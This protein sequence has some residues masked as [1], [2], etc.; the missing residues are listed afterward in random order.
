MTAVTP[1]RGPQAFLRRTRAAGGGGF[2]PSDIAGLALWLKADGTLWQDSGRT[3]PASSDAD[4]VGAW[5]DAS[6]ND[7]HY[8][9]ATAGSRPA[10]KTGIVNGLPVVR[11]DGASDYLAGPNHLSAL[12]A[13]TAFVVV[14]IDNDPPGA[15]DQSGLWDMDAASD[16]AH[17][18]FTDGNVYDGWGSTARKSTGNPTLS[19]SAAFRVYGVVSASGA[20]TS[21]VDGTQHYT[22]GTNTVGFGTAPEFGRSFNGAATYYYLDGDVAEVIV[23]DS[24]LG[25]TDRQSVEGYLATKYG[26]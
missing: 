6:G 12:T 11:F 15:A 21:Y 23:Y 10:F 17:Y 14:K 5:D 4:P 19:L 20:W 24:A 2:S 8:T 9:Q 7:D 22:T 18:P 16:A 3:T 13:A 1:G 26:L 25:T